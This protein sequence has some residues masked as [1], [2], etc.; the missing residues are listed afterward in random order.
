M[1]LVRYSTLTFLTYGTDIYSN[2][3]HQLW[4]IAELTREPASADPYERPRE[5]LERS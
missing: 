3:L 4:W 2:A 1:G 5:V